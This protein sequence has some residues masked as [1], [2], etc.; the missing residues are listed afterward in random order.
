LSKLPIAIFSKKILI[1]NAAD[2]EQ[3]ERNPKEFGMPHDLWDVVNA[4]AEE[5]DVLHG[6]PLIL[7]GESLV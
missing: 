2:D 7:V 3:D 6:S 4:G 5:D 1:K